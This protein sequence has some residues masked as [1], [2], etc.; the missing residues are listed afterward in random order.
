MGPFLILR[1][2]SGYFSLTDRVFVWYK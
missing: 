1:F 2:R